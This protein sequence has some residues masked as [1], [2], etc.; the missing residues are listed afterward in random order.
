MR[1]RPMPALEIYRPFARTG[2]R[3]P[4]ASTGLE[5]SAFRPW[6]ASHR[7]TAGPFWGEGSGRLNVAEAFYRD[8]VAA[9]RGRALTVPSPFGGA[10]VSTSD[11]LVAPSHDWTS[12]PMF[13]FR[14]CGGEPFHF[15][16]R[17]HSWCNDVGFVLPDRRLFVSFQEDDRWVAKDA[18]D[19][20]RLFAFAEPYRARRNGARP[21]RP[22]VI[23]NSD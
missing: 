23:V 7:A 11:V 1:E 20:D 6:S 22:C 2:H 16:K 9:I 8:A 18:A 5:V 4:A 10:P 12:V 15:V 21:R 19:V 3:R 17:G 13:A 14:F